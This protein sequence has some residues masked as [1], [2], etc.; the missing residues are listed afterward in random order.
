MKAN[1]T[2]LLLSFLTNQ[3]TTA[4]D[5]YEDAL[6]QLASGINTSLGLTETATMVVSEFTRMDG[7]G[8]DVDG[9]LTMD[10]E[11]ALLAKPHM[12]RLLDRANLEAMAEEHKLEMNGMMDQEQRMKEAGKLLKADA[13]VFGSYRLVG[14]SLVL[15]VKAVDIQTSEQ[16]AIIPANCQPNQVIKDICGSEGMATTDVAKPHRPPPEVPAAVTKPAKPCTSNNG[17]ICFQ[18]NSDRE[19]TVFLKKDISSVQLSRGR[20]D[21]V[22]VRPGRQECYFDKPVGTYS[23]WI[24]EGYGT[25]AATDVAESNLRVEGC[26]TGTF[27][28]P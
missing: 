4:Q 17:S 8:C 20:G 19:I 6:A 28:Y 14:S 10:F 7:Q 11:A 23:Y 27:A 5:K 9:M 16:L 1:G 25:T 22:L 2:L 24:V 3:T 18:N 15:R 13:I 26:K 12:Y 21:K